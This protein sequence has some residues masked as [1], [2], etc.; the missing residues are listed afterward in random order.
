MNNV[1][2]AMMKVREFQSFIFS[3]DASPNKLFEKT[4]E[5]IQYMEKASI[6]IKTN[7]E[8]ISEKLTKEMNTGVK[9]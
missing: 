2:L 4:N 1:D 3:A 9:Q 5:I 7:Y 8:E 6:E